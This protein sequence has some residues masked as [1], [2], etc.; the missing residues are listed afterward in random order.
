MSEGANEPGATYTHTLCMRSRW[1]M[2]TRIHIVLD[3]AEK[4]R[5]RSQA[6]REGKSL[7]A[8]PREAAAE[9]LAA[10]RSVRRLRTVGDL[11]AF[12]AECDDRET[13]P[14]PDWREHGRVIERSRAEG[15]E[16]T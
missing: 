15:M 12:F 6:D 11:E 1:A 14:E 16:V 10:A 9:K 8:W 5:Y 4:A 13:R 2:T 7:G 3:E